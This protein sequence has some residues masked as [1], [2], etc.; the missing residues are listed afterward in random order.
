MVVVILNAIDGVG[1]YSPL[2]SIAAALLERNDVDVRFLVRHSQIG[3]LTK[4]FAAC[5]VSKANLGG[6]LVGIDDDRDNEMAVRLAEARGGNIPL[7]VLELNETRQEIISRAIESLGLQETDDVVG[8][9]DMFSLGAA[10]AFKAMGAPFVMT[11]PGPAALLSVLGPL[12]ATNLDDLFERMSLRLK[13]SLR[14]KTY[15]LRAVM[16][17]MVN[18]CALCFVSSFDETASRQATCM[19]TLAS[20]PEK[21]HLVRTFGSMTTPKKALEENITP[22]IAAFLQGAL[23]VVVVTGSTVSEMG[24]SPYGLR[25][26]YDGCALG[27][28]KWRVVWRIC[29]QAVFEAANI[30]SCDEDWI[31]FVDWLPQAALLAHA[32]VKCVCTHMGW[33][34]TTEAL[35]SG[36]P[37]LGV[38]IAADQPM[39]AQLA[40]RLACGI[41]LDSA[42]LSIPPFGMPSDPLTRDPE[43]FSARQVHDALARI[44]APDSTFAASTANARD[45]FFPPNEGK[46]PTYG[47]K[48]VASVI[49][50]ECVRKT[51]TEDAPVPIRG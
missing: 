47:P 43:R 15:E 44:L 1:H 9:A 33:N 17:E 46:V 23:P 29:N 11:I 16:E 42:D 14:A 49:H 3:L 6:V 28:D 4:L 24:P 20:L 12:P 21:V 36:T 13:P 32:N 41:A 5:G 26:L 48:Y 51:P 50:E 2:V 37:M 22:T 18:D 40:A 30:P 38:P 35:A 27:K 39:N 45:T 34:S 31:T 25:T 8:V 7:P 10:R 19:P